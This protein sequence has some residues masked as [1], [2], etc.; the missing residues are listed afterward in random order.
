MAKKRAYTDEVVS[1][2]PAPNNAHAKERDNQDYSIDEL[3]P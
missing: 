3:K 1:N 2:I